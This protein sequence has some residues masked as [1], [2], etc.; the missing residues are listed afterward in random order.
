MD[1][2]T[3]TH[4]PLLVA[5]IEK[6]NHDS[7]WV[8]FSFIEPDRDKRE[9][10][11]GTYHLFTEMRKALI[12]A[13]GNESW[14]IRYASRVV[15]ENLH[16]LHSSNTLQV[17]IDSLLPYRDPIRDIFN[18]GYLEFQI[19]DSQAYFFKPKN[20][21]SKIIDED[22]RLKVLARAANEPATVQA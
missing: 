9:K 2:P 18:T 16:F 14:S 3:R 4:T 11:T 21:A 6:S 8:K 15:K 10:I 5:K 22:K 19:T 12:K 20:D 13:T 7:E 17:V 1:Q